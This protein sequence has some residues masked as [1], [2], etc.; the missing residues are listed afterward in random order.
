MKKFRDIPMKATLKNSAIILS[1]LILAACGSSDNSASNA[2]EEEH[3]HEMMISQQ[4]TDT[5]S[6]L[7]EGNAEALDDT[8]AANGATLL[9]SNTGE[10]VAIITTGAV[11]F[12]AVHHEE[13]GEEEEGHEEEHELP[14]LSSLSITAAGIKVVNTNGHFSVL[15]DGATQLVPYES[16]EEGATAEA[17]S[18]S[19]GITETYPALLLEEGESE[20]VVLAFGGDEAVIYENGEASVEVEHSKTC[21]VVNSSAQ[22]GEF[23]LVSCDGSSF[24]VKLEESAVEGEEHTIQL[25]NIE[26]IS[27]AVDWTTRA[28]VFVGY[29]QTDNKFYVVEEATVAD[30]EVLELE[31][32]FAATLDSAEL[33]AWG[34]DSLSADIFALTADTLTVFNHLGESHSLTLDET[35]NADCDDLRLA[36]ANKAVFVMDNQA[37]V[38]YEIDKEED[39][40]EYHIHGREDLSVNDV[41]SAIVFHEVGTEAEAHDH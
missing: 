13:E 3:G 22:N 26:D 4:G 1:S 11:Q 37:Q 41:A 6:F 33:C 8:A 23:A 15:A 29:G 2:E 19:L 38:L 30:E 7:E 40:A 21:D 16:L 39:A 27:T 28:G 9:L 35:Q 36:T 17:E 34:I 25:I 20:V 14:E 12:V 24:S 10:Q 5:L 31:S 18:L 32:S